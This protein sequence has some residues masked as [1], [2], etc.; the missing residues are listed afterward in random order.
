MQTRD[1]MDIKLAVYLPQIETLEAAY[2]ATNGVY[3]QITNYNGELDI[4]ID[5]YSNGAGAFGYKVRALAKEGD[6]LYYRIVD[7]NQQSGESTFGWEI[8]HNDV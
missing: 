3:Q 5:Q 8:I 4:N 1:E 2:F 6:D 7:S